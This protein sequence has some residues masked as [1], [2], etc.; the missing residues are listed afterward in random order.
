MLKKAISLLL[1]APLLMVVSGSALA[2][3]SRGAV[4]SYTVTNLVSDQPGEAEHVDPNMVNAW[5]LAA[6]PTSPWWVANAETNVSTLYMGDGTPL[7]LVVKVQGHPTGTVFNGGSDFVVGHNGASGPSVFMFAT[8]TGTIRGWNPSVPPPAPS[9]RS[10]LVVDRSS[11]HAVYKGLTLAST[12]GGDFL[13]ATDF[14]NARVDVFDGDFN[15]V[16]PPGAFQDPNLPNR[17]APF[18][19]REIGGLILVTYAKQNGAGE[20]D[21]PGPG[22]GF[23]D[24]FDTNGT[25]LARVGTR[26]TLNAPWGLAL[27]PES[28]GAF[29][30]DLLVGNFGDGEIHA[31]KLQAN[32][33]AK[34]EGALKGAN[35][36]LAI[37]GL[38]ALSFG[39]DG[40]AGSSES[41]FFT[42]GPDDEEHG[43]FGRIEVS[44]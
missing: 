28:F 29:G 12:V 27:A 38:W 15:L 6:S 34:H 11:E 32:G 30:G 1:V 13:Y 37:D 35:G 31:Y 20:D 42:A 5:G 14:R 16:T 23:V 4:N 18:G 41:L 10:F 17:Y 26:G 22:R 7:S 43:L 33:T 21:V 8:E 44:P 39:N 3:S 2:A 24:A 36:N 9:T 19:I 40:Q 25:L